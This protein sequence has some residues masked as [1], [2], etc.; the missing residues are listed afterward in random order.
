MDNNNTFRDWIPEG[1][2]TGAFTE[3]GYTD[4][5]PA[6]EPKRQEIKEEKPKK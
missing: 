6:P 1:E 5:V 2:D 3:N 4:F